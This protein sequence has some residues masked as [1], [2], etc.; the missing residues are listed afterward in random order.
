LP[1]DDLGRISSK[2]INIL[3]EAAEQN[4][5]LGLGPGLSVSGDLRCVI[6]KLLEQEGLRLIIDADGLNNT[7]GL[8][9]WPAKLKAN[10]VL[11]PHPGEMK[12]LWSALFREPMPSDRSQQA[13]QFARH[14]NTLVVL[15]GAGTVVSDGQKVYVN[16][17]GN[18]GMATA[19]SGDVLTG[20]ITA[21]AGQGLDNFD[22][23][24]LGVY[25]HGVAGDIAAEKL[26]QTSLMTT[27]IIDELPGAFKRIEN[28]SLSDRTT[29]VDS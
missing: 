13:V 20:I 11:T 4:D 10:P 25:V 19:G 22:G 6:E 9:D 24:V 27:D 23:A 28:P 1:E 17:T 8:K 21:L 7:A 3:L 2:A 12:R 15:K 26:G 29:A 14:T 18:P 5:C 16:T